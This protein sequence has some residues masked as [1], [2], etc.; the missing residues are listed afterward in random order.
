MALQQ[1]QTPFPVKSDR[2]QDL[3]RAAYH[4]IAHKGFEGLRVREV[5]AL[6]GMNGATLHHYFPTKELLIQAVVDSVIA[7]LSLA[8]TNLSGTPAEQLHEHLTRLHRLMQEESALFVVLTE[9]NLRAQRD[10]VLHFLVEQET[11]WHE[12]LVGLL[13]AGVEQQNWPPDLDPSTTASAIISLVEGASLWATIMPSRA[14]QALSQLE[15]WL[16]TR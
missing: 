9:I 1:N 11:L 3:I 7:R 14:E 2:R 5:A 4:T 16:H 8:F 6:V 12:R 15:H 13:Q 10:P